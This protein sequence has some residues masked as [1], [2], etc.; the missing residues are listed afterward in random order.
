MQDG[1]V[2]DQSD[3]NR[4]IWA[5]RGRG[6]VPPAQLVRVSMVGVTMAPKAYSVMGTGHVVASRHR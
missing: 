1:E 2:A 5:A 4:S 6:L 3:H